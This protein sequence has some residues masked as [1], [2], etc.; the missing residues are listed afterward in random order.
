MEV[1]KGQAFGGYYDFEHSWITK[2]KIS[3]SLICLMIPS[4]F[5]TI[6]FVICEKLEGLI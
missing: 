3:C 5:M 4:D 2:Y 6:L 1:I